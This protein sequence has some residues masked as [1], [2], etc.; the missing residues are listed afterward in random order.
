MNIQFLLIVPFKL[1]LKDN[2]RLAPAYLIEFL[3]FNFHNAHLECGTLLALLYINKI[4]NIAKALLQH[5]YANL[6]RECWVG[7]IFKTSIDKLLL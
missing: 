5:P 2:K 1:Y 6:H 7:L 3:M 4:T